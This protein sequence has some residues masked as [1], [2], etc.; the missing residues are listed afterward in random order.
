MRKVFAQTLTWTRLHALHS[1]LF[2]QSQYI[3]LPIHTRSITYQRW[4]GSLV[5]SWCEFVLECRFMKF[6]LPCLDRFLCAGIKK[7]DKVCTYQ[8]LMCKCGDLC[9]YALIVKPYSLDDLWYTGRIIITLLEQGHPNQMTSDRTWSQKT[10]LYSRLGKIQYPGSPPFHSVLEWVVIST[11][12]VTTSD[13]PY[14]HL[15]V[16]R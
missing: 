5:Y 10:A 9:I 11:H 16:Q 13:Q 14:P 2:S 8:T 7:D 12:K 3:D 4:S 6:K 1:S 15:R